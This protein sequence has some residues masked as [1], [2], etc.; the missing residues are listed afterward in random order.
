M[1]NRCCVP[2]LSALALLGTGQALAA[3]RVV[4]SSPLG[5]V[6]VPTS[7]AVSIPVSFSGIADPITGIGISGTYVTQQG[8]FDDG[9]GP[10]SLD[11]RLTATA[12]GG[13]SLAWNPIGGDVTI[14]DYP[15]QD[16]TAGLPSVAGD[17]AW[18]FAFDSVVPQS[19]WTY[20]IDNA[21][22]YVLAEA[23]D[24][25]EAY[26]ATPDPA[27]QWNRPFFIAGV[28][29]LGPVAYDAFSF[30]V[31]VSGVY[32]FSS[33]LST[34]GNHFSFLYGGG[35]D[36]DQPL[37]N[38][39]DYGLGNGNS[40][41]GVPRGESR[42]EALL[43]EGVTYTWVTSQ[44]DRFGSIAP[45]SN[46]IVGPGAV[47]PVGDD[48]PADTNGNGALD[49]GDFTAWVTAYNAGDVP[50]ADQNGNGALDPGDFTAWVT[51]YNAGCP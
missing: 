12:P 9:L 2:V 17:G 34:G 31:G 6:V 16:G 13:A 35:F 27:N 28:S 39:I 21:V 33:V 25:T 32:E 7:T 8:D 38:L 5:T 15:F 11:V 10:W 36:A 1:Q 14:A 3:D 23:P 45:A 41:F 19:N 47:V 46:T 4:A 49:P 18:T 40:P 42:I 22:V 43:F 51:N 20:R 50:T 29:G 44:W 26:T 24:V 48:C 30:T 37:A